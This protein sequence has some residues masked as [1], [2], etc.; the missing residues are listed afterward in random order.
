MLKKFNKSLS[1]LWNSNAGTSK[2]MCRR[3]IRVSKKPSC[4]ALARNPTG[5]CKRVWLLC[6]FFKT[7]EFRTYEFQE[8]K[9]AQRQE[10]L[11]KNKSKIALISLK[12]NA[13]G[14]QF[15]LLSRQTSNRNKIMI[16]EETILWAEIICSKFIKINLLESIFIQKMN[17]SKNSNRNRCEVC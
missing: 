7:L 10:E 15:L 12:Q 2:L 13:S 17:S 14:K 8:Y 6:E 11:A 3:G 9:F 4:T 5:V 1:K 16:Y